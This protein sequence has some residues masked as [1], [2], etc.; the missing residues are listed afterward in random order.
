[1]PFEKQTETKKAKR[2]LSAIK[3]KKIT[4]SSTHGN[5]M[6]AEKTN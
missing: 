4:K 1:M 3:N 2:L 6:T 5:F